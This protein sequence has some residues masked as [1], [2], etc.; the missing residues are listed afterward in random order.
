MNGSYTMPNLDPEKS[1]KAE[2][3]IPH[4]FATV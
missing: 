2:Q 1:T 4:K 3:N